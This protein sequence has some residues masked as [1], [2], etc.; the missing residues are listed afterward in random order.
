MKYLSLIQ[1]VFE[2][3]GDIVLLRVDGIFQ[4]TLKHKEKVLYEFALFHI[5]LSSC[6]LANGQAGKILSL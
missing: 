1:F 5:S 3:L 4:K 6:G 2:T